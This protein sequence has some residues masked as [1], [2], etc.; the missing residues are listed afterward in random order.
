MPAEARQDHATLRRVVHR[1]ARTGWPQAAP[2]S[3]LAG[4]DVAVLD[5][6][7]P[8]PL[9]VEDSPDLL[10]VVLAEEDFDSER[11]SVR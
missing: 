11:L 10:D 1:P 7:S 3:L 2:A 4:V 6:E 9:E 8:E 5:E